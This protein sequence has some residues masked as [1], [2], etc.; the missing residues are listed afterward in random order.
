MPIARRI[1]SALA[2]ALLLGL[3]ATAQ[4]THV[5]EALESDQQAVA[6]T[7]QLLGALRQWQQAP[8]AARAA[9]AAALERLA[10]LRRERLL[11]LM[12]RNPELAALRLLPAPLRAQ[13]PASLR[14]LLE[15]DVALT[16][17]VYAEVTRGRDGRSEQRFFFQP[18]GGASRYALQLAEEA[19]RER[20]L[21]GWTGRALR[22]N[23]VR[24]DGQLLLRGK[25]DGELV[26]AEGAASTSTD[27][28][29]TMTPR[30]T[31]NQR[32]LVILAN[33]ND[34]TVGCSAA[35]VQ[36]RMFG[37]SGATTNVD[38]LQSSEALVSFS[39]QAAGPFTINYSASGACSFDAWGSAAD[40]AARAAG[41][42]PSQFQRIN[43]VTPPNSSCGWSGL[44]Y[45][46][47][48]RSW[49]QSCG[50]TGVYVHE[51]GHNLSFHHA[52]T[53]SL[54]YGD[55][56]DPMGG[57]RMV[58]F[59]APNRVLAGWLPT[60]SVIEVLTSGGYSL[61]PLAAD[62]SP[63][64]QV[65]RLVKPDTNEHYYVSLRQAID[66]DANLPAGY[67]NTLSIHRSGSNM[68]TRTY[69][70]QNL[71]VGQ[72]FTDSVN[73]LQ[74]TH[75]GLAGSVSTVAVDFT[76]STCQ[77]NAPT[78]GVSPASQTGA[79]GAQLGYS[80]SVRNNNT[81]ACGGSAFNVAQTLPAGF[82]GT[83]STGSL[84]L[85]AGASSSVS[86]QVTSP[87]TAAEATHTLTATASE[88]AV[89]NSASQ[90]ASYI[91]FRDS[92]A[93]SLT[94]TSPA[95]GATLSGS[96]ATLAASASDGSGVT[97]VE[98]LVDGQLLT[99]DTSAPYSAKWNLRKTGKGAHTVSVRATDAYGNA[100]TQ[101]LQVTVN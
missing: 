32:T 29:V 96:S 83:L 75:Q 48:T 45:M 24:L 25:A 100:A 56:S 47:G 5:G 98:F 50:S 101:S 17:T 64:P 18:Q 76:G 81:A 63:N 41:I 59:N 40:A 87:T 58:Q 69:L 66:L 52:A 62:G 30:V 4:A 55:S 79:P 44:A 3:A 2:A 28:V 80:I 94:I 31:G 97:A 33:F 20:T 19:G 27:G 15:Q 38:Y 61:S 72:S 42:D 53:P 9:R 23:G 78:V 99:R 86:W 92:V 12:Q 68:P 73:G 11:A 67:Q 35:D 91:V 14:G 22:V 21:L 71:A 82:A 13:F 49:V 88:S 85:A 89:A 26:A 74:I 37:S 39:G 1:P 46:P 16:G 57:A 10:L 77:R 95:A 36:A 90:H 54:E 84:T 8:A 65:L 34:A 6:G 43:Y 51:L 7:D 93:P 60:G 70:L